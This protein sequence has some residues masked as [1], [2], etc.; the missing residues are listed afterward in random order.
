MARISPFRAV[1]VAQMARLKRQISAEFS[2]RKCQCR[3]EM[4]DNEQWRGLLLDASLWREQ[5]EA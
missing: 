2:E 4:H 3:V 1:F 5:L